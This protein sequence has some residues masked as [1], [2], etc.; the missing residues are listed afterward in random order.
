M[1]KVQRSEILPLGEYEAIREPFRARVIRE[2]KQRRIALGDRATCVFENHDSA[3]MQIQEMLRTERITKESAIL[4]EIETYNALVPGDHEV[5][6]TMMIEI[7]DAAAR[8]AFLVAARGLEDAITLEVDG[9]SFPALYEKPLAPAARTTAVHYFKFAL[10]DAATKKLAAAKN[11]ALPVS[12][13]S[14][15]PAYAVRTQLPAET[16]ASLAEDFA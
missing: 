11:G 8:D 3:L 15:H 12:V 10:S 5:S 2:K 9:E 16:V 7:N 13:V 14:K 1:Q 6:A 4:H